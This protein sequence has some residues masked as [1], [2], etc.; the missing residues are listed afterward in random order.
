MIT[1]FFILSEQ[2]VHGMKLIKIILLLLLVQVVII[3]E[4]QAQKE[5][6][7]L[8]ILIEEEN[9]ELNEVDRVDVLNALCQNL[10][11]VSSDRALDY[12]SRALSLSISNGYIQGQARA[13]R[14]LA[15]LYIFLGDFV[16]SANYI[17]RAI[18]IF[19]QQ[20]DSI[21]IA[22]CYITLGHTHRAQKNRTQEVYYHKQSY[23]IFCRLNIP[24]RIGVTAHNLGESYLNNKEYERGRIY[25]LIAIRTNLAVKN[26]PVLS[27]CYKVLGI[28]DYKTGNL[29]EA[30]RNFNMVL[31]LS[32]QLGNNSQKLALAQ[33]MLF[34]SYICKTK[35]QGENQLRYLFKVVELAKKNNLEE[36]IQIS[37]YEIINY[38]LKKGDSR[39]ADE[40]LSEYIKASRKISEQ[41]VRQTQQLTQYMMAGIDSEK[42]RERLDSEQRLQARL[43]DARNKQLAIT[44]TALFFLILLVLIIIRVNSKLKETLKHLNDQAIFRNK[45]YSVLLHDLK[46]PMRF[47]LSNLRMWYNTFG[48]EHTQAKHIVYDLLQSTSY[49]YRFMEEFHGWIVRSENIPIERE[50][51]NLQDLFSE[52]I[53]FYAPLAAHKGNTIQSPDNEEIILK[54]K[55]QALKIILRNL[56]DNALK[57]TTNGRISLTI[58]SGVNYLNVCVEDS[59][60]GISPEILA[61]ILVTVNG[62]TMKDIVPKFSGGLGFNIIGEF[63][64]SE[65]ALLCVDSTLEVGTKI[66]LSLRKA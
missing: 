19:R 24:E 22:N 9:P 61:G 34:L 52:L 54:V 37:Y 6:D 13:Y 51:I 55:V 44:G 43:L 1:V 25:T 32:N 58:S 2:E 7:S 53:E 17:T 36:I 48:N 26:L 28:I 66:I 49:A 29:A 11:Y 46:S 30:E 35:R 65:N 59:G 41:E 5:I 62:E 63:L 10:I 27:N 60:K 39:N 18:S 8:E 47:I 12:G 21:G 40:M 38:Y 42:E 57:N 20:Q 50:L 33:S 56:I 15:S 31:E 45:I 23:E 4:T 14:N 16:L 3:I 64:R